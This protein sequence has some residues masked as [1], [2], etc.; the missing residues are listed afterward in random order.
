MIGVSLPQRSRRLMVVAAFLLV[1]VW[2][3]LSLGQ[4]RAQVFHREDTM[5]KTAV[6]MALSALGEIR[7]FLAQSLWFQTDVYHHAYEERG[8]PWSQE[9]DVMALYRMITLLDP[10]FEGAY[11]VGSFQ[12][13]M[14][15]K[16]PLE[17][18]EFVNEGLMNNPDSF[19]LWFDKGFYLQHMERYSEAIKAYEKAMTISLLPD[20]W[21]RDRLE[22]I[23]TLRQL[24]HCFRKTSHRQGE[25]WALQS[26][27]YIVPDDSYALRRLKELGV[28]PVAPAPWVK[29]SPAP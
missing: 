22:Y 26:L 28:E 29:E 25:V 11:D 6:G 8:I 9:R 7:T 2:A 17:G 1:L 4:W 14:H 19:T 5:Q 16:K 13:V 27:V 18:L 23:N 10:R 3:N 20:H 15:F 21:S 12:L 24:G